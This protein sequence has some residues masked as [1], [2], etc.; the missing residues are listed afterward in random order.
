MIRTI[1]PITSISARRPGDIELSLI[2][3]PA[4]PL[5]AVDLTLDAPL[6]VDDAS[7]VALLDAAIAR[8]R[9]YRSDYVKAMVEDE[10]AGAACAEDRAAW[11]RS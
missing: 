5:A 7:Y 8:L 1:E 6:V 9:L 11:A 2:F 4:A 10:D 3:D